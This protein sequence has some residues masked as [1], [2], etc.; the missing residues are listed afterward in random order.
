M[1]ISF[2]TLCGNATLFIKQIQFDLNGNNNLFKILV[3]T[4][5][6]YKYWLFT[7]NKEYIDT[8]KLMLLNTVD[9]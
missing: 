9:K 5:I 6:Y 1:N 7:F 4:Q 8:F 2:V 3:V